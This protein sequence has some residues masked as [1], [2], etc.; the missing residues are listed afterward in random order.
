MALE[1][2]VFSTQTMM[3]HDFVSL[4]LTLSRIPSPSLSAS[5][6]YTSFRILCMPHSTYKTF[7]EVSV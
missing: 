5:V 6:T 1:D 4:L 3:F 2:E 7:T